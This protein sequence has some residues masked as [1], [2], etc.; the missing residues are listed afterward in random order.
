MSSRRG[1]FNSAAVVF[2]DLQRGLDLMQDIFLDI[3]VIAIGQQNLPHCCG[4]RAPRGV[5]NLLTEYPREIGCAWR[6]AFQRFTCRA[7]FGSLDRAEVE[8]MCEYLVDRGNLTGG[9]ATISKG[10][11]H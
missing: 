11:A 8:C 1:G 4:E 9:V 6:V 7:Q 10:D 3:G 2:G 5:I